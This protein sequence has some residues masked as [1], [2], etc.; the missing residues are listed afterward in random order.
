[1][2]YSEG[3]VPDVDEVGVI[4]VRKNQYTFHKK[5]RGLCDSKGVTSKINKVLL[6]ESMQNVSTL[7]CY[8]MNCC[9][10][11]LRKKTL[12]L[13]QEYWSLSCEGQKAYGLDNPRRLHIKGDINPQTFITTHVWIFTKLLGTRS[14]VCLG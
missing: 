10:H 13:R 3:V 6:E 5:K 8:G 9:Q 2:K 12:F 1:V 7:T 14:L 11:F 4:G